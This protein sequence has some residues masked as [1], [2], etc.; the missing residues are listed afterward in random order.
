MIVVRFLN[1]VEM[2][3]HEN[4]VKDTQ[5]VFNLLGVSVGGEGGKS[6][7]VDLTIDTAQKRLKYAYQ[8]WSCT[9]NVSVLDSLRFLH[10]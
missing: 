7:Y 8:T 6:K 5:H 10:F 2:R 1:G 4:C 3:S 9:L